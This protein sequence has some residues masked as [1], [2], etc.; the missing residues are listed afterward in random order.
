M[1]VETKNKPKKKFPKG[2]TLKPAKL[3]NF[4]DKEANRSSKE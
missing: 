2:A 3:E 4:W 1:R